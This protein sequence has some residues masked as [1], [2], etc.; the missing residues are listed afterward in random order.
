M[1]SSLPLSLP[2]D[3][4]VYKIIIAISPRRL[5]LCLHISWHL[6]SVYYFG[7][8]CLVTLSI[9]KFIQ[10][11]KTSLC[12][13]WLQYRKL[14]VMFKLSPA[15]L[16][17]FIDTPNCVLEDRVQSSTVRIVQ[18]STVRIVNVFWDGHGKCLKM[19]RIFFHVFCTVIIRCTETIWSP[20]TFRTLITKM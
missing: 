2:N 4:K 17:T 11:D 18:Y 9:T 20:C 1:S 3:K 6:I 5:P 12:T 13:W 16:Q 8:K 14:Q 15:S 10:G 7:V 19:F